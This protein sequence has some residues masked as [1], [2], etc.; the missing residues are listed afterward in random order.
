MKRRRASASRSC[1]ACKR[2]MDGEEDRA[3]RRESGPSV[4]FL[5]VFDRNQKTQICCRL[6]SLRAL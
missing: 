4:S 1:F 2:V 5:L 3:G 6:K